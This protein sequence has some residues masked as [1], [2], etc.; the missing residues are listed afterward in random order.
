[1][2]GGDENE[3]WNRAKSLI[4]G[5]VEVMMQLKEVKKADPG[6]P[7][8]MSVKSGVPVAQTCTS[9]STSVLVKSYNNPSSKSKPS[10]YNEHRHMYNWILAIKSL[11]K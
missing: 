4:L 11:F 3:S 10:I 9:A 5:A 1:M 8:S 6:P 7:E 2:S